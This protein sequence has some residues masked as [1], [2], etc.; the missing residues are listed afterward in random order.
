MK[1]TILGIVLVLMA[2][3]MLAGCSVSYSGGES[4]QGKEQNTQEEKDGCL[5]EG[6]FN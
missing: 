6:L 1:K 2:S 5:D 4:D 3:L